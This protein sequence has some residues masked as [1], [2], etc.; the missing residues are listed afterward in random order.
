MRILGSHNGIGS[1]G[2]VYSTS[3][4]YINM[5]TDIIYA[6]GFSGTHYGTWSGN[7]IPYSSIS[8]TPTVGNGTITISQTGRANQTFT[9]NQTGNT[10]ISL[11][12]NNTTYTRASFI[13]QSVDTGANVHFEGL[14]VGQAS[15]S[16]ANTCLLYTSPSPRD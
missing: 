5:S 12:D 14:M 16:T 3:Q 7:A 15:G 6:T 4:V 11:N 9:V 10:T 1:N 2:N 8:G 13:N